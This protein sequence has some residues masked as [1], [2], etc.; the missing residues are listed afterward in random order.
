MRNTRL[1]PL[2]APSQGQRA[3]NRYTL[4]GQNVYLG[5]CAPGSPIKGR[6]ED[7]QGAPRSAGLGGQWVRGVGLC[8]FAVGRLLGPRLLILTISFEIAEGRRGAD[9]PPSY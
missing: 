9:P 6:A 2:T 7:V 8:G 4:N 3:R 1:N 5:V